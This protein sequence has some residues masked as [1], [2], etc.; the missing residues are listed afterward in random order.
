MTNKHNN[1]TDYLSI[2]DPAPYCNVFIDFIFPQHDDNDII[3]T[4]DEKNMIVEQI[5]NV[6]YH[7]DIAKSNVYNEN[8][9]DAMEEIGVAINISTC[10]KCKKRMLIAAYDINHASNVCD[11]DEGRCTGLKTDINT[12]IEDFVNNYL[13]RVEEVLSA[14]EN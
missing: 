1:M 3:L 4:K 2:L 7:L 6:K 11:L 9:E 12:I 8:F 5:D 13:P 10:G 14:R